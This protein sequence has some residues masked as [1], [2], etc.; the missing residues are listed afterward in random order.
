MDLD[1]R[2]T[3]LLRALLQLGM[4][5]Q[6]PLRLTFPPLP[7]PEDLHEVI[8]AADEGRDADH[9]LHRL[10]HRLTE[11]LAQTRICLH[12]VPVGAQ[13]DPPD[14][15]HLLLVCRVEEGACLDGVGEAV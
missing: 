6:I 14:S 7:N 1:R 2:A 11:L 13:V 9:S 15:R 8:H 3:Q 12:R 4:A 5:V 10:L